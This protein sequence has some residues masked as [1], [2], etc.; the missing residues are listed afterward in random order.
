MFQG[1]H[2]IGYLTDDI[3]AARSLF[4]DKFGGKVL[5]EST[6]A[7]GNK[8]LFMRMGAV[9]VEV[10][11]PADKAR[12]GGKKGLVIE[13]VGFFVEEFESAKA[14][15]EQKGVKFVASAA[16]AGA[17]RPRIA[18]METESTLGTRIH[19]SRIQP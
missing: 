17:A 12:L 4:A 15:L 19:L 14:E 2:H 1:V 9:E 8:A 18:Y 5:T 6:N 7:E 3:D 11:E 13:H 10:I 16:A